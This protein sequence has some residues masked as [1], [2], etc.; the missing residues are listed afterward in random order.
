M[1]SC[2]DLKYAQFAEK[3]TNNLELQ[4][5]KYYRIYYTDENSDQIIIN[6]PEDYDIFV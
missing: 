4:K 2:K 1:L 3:V 5:D 6:T